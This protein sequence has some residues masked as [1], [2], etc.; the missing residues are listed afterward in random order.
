MWETL[1]MLELKQHM[2]LQSVLSNIYFSSDL[3]RVWITFHHFGP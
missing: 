2:A 1:N 3:R